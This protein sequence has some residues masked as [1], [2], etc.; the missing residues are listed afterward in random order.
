MLISTPAMRTFAA[1]VRNFAEREAK[2]LYKRSV[3]GWLWS[4][5]KPLTAVLVYSLVFGVIYRTTPPATANG[6]A[7]T[8]SLYL[9]SGLVIWNLF[10]SVVLGSMQWLKGVSDLRKKVYFPTET[11]VLGGAVS[12]FLQSTLEALVLVI[13]MAGFGNISWTVVYLPLALVLTAMA[14][15]GIGFTVSIL[16]IRYRD[17]EYLTG[18]LLN[19]AFFLVPIVFTPDLVPERAYGLPIRRLLDLNPLSSIIGVARERGVLPEACGIGA[20]DNRIRMVKCCIRSR[21]DLLPT[22]L[23]ADQRRTITQAVSTK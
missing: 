22:P 8:F 11:A 10:T 21:V 17:I 1:L 14:A 15:L 18:I 2:S 13:V 3:L 7:E 9:F 20:A 12:A 5:I 6:R 4:L 19:I 16:N 23:H